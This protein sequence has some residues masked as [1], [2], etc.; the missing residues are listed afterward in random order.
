[1]T[2]TVL[3]LADHDRTLHFGSALLAGPTLLVL[4]RGLRLESAEWRSRLTIPFRIVL[5]AQF[6]LIINWA[7][8]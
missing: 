3:A 5:L 7:P 2:V 6:L 8:A 4:L 1:M